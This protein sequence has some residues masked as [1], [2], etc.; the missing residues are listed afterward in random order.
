M[1]FDELQ[2]KARAA[3]RAQEDTK[4]EL[5]ELLPVMLDEALQ[6]NDPKN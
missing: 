4:Q 1:W 3:R 6:S 2:T 5:E